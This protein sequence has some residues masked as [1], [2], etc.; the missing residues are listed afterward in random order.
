MVDPLGECRSIRSECRLY[1]R[2]RGAVLCCQ[3]AGQTAAIDT[4]SPLS[5]SWNCLKRHRSEYYARLMAV[6]QEGNWEGWLQFFL[7]GV[8]ETAEEATDTARAIVAM[9]EAH[10]ELLRTRASGVNEARLLDLLFQ[11]P[12]VN[13]ALVARLLDVT[14]VTATR[15]VDQLSQ[16]GLLEEITGRKRDRVFRYTPYWRLFQDV[17]ELD[18][19]GGL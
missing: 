18:D 2:H 15:L 8:A 12:L 13:V 3:P 1:P 11:R 7:R 14:R 6:R 5:F 19:V 16:A 10:H 17:D 9:R 4:I